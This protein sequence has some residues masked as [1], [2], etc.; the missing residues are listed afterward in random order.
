M[1]EEIK[2]AA[3]AAVENLQQEEQP[4]LPA[5]TLDELESMDMEAIA[6]PEEAEGPRQFRITDDSCADWAVRKIAAERAELARLK[7]LAEEQIDRIKEQIA[8]AEKRCENETNYFI[9]MLARYFET[10]PHKKTKTQLS[11]RLLS[12]T[13]KRKIGGKTKKPAK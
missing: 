2:K 11:Y 3:D 12:G 9:T 7:A 13:L 8:A 6:S 1:S 5:V 10:V 4:E